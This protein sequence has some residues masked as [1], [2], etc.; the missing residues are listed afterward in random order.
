ML[1]D[2]ILTFL[3]DL[4]HHGRRRL[5][6]APARNHHPDT[7]AEELYQVP[8]NQRLRVKKY[9]FNIYLPQG[10]QFC[11]ATRKM[12]TLVEHLSKAPIF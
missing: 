9:I 3:K 1:N 7:E 11:Q 12:S 10:S 8:E 4:A 5:I 2:K 6:M